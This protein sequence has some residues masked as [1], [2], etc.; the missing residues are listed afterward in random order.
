MAARVLLKVPD[1]A[2]QANVVFE[3]VTV[4]SCNITKISKSVSIFPPNH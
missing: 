4:V 2:E 3:R 1:C